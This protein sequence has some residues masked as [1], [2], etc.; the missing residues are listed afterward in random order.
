MS[1]TGQPRMVRTELKIQEVAT[2]VHDNCSQVL[3]EVTAAAAGIRHGP[4]QR[5][6]S[7]DPNMSHATQHSVQRI[8]TQD[9]HDDRMS[10]C[11]DL[12]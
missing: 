7:D 4:C 11:G 3:N 12:I 2:L 5:I 9:Q 1:I 8:L 10:A 6:L